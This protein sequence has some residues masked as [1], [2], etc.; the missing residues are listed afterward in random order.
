MT[1]RRLA[2]TLGASFALLTASCT[3][4]GDGDAGNGRIERDGGAGTGGSGAGTAGT[5]GTG[6]SGGSSATGGAGTGGSGAGT[7]GT[8]GTGGSG[9]SSATGGAGTGGSGAGTAGTTGT[10]G[11]GGSS[12]TG[13]AGTGGSGA[14]TAGTTGTGGR[15]GG[16]GSAMGPTGDPLIDKFVCPNQT[17]GPTPQAAVPSIVQQAYQHAELTAYIHFGLDTF[18]GTEQGNVSDTPMVFNPTN[19]TQATVD[20]WVSTLQ[21]AGFQQAQ[22]TTKH[23]TGFCLWPSASTSYSVA[24]SPWMGGKGDLVKMF[25]DGM[26]KAGM[27]AALYLAPWD[28]HVPSSSASYTQ[29][30]KTQFTELMS[31]YGT[32]YETTFDGFN[33][34]GSN[35]TPATVNW[36]DT[37]RAGA[38]AAVASPHLGGPRGRPARHDRHPTCDSRSPVDRQRERT[39]ESHDLEP[40]R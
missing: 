18:D 17:G 33:S 35:G 7:A 5:T 37:F 16:G 27:R 31:N 6:G 21:A 38:D 2:Y 29:A 30:F 12:A 22:L 32:V 39:G 36:A 4:P 34:P 40:E 3:S 8:T 28:Q 24:N 19:L 9:G 23:S 15:G 13:G 1:N 20:H 14:G 11:S 25:T 26:K 10:G